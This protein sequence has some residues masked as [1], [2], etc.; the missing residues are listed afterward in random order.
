MSFTFKSSNSGLL[1]MGITSKLTLLDTNSSVNF[2]SLNILDGLV[3]EY[4]DPGILHVDMN[5]LVTAGQLITT[6]ISNLA[7]TSEK[8]EDSI[9]LSGIPTTTTA[10]TG[11]ISQI[12]TT[13]FVQNTIDNVLGGAS[14][15]LNT[16][17]KLAV[18]IDGKVS[19]ADDE[20]IGGTKTFIN[21]PV[22]SVL[23]TV[24]IV[25]N[26]SDGT[27]YTDLIKTNDINNDTIN[28]DKLQNGIVTLSK[29]APNAVDETIIATGAVTSD[30]I[31]PNAVI[32]E[33][34]NTGAVTS[35]KIAPNAV[36]TETI[37]IGAVTLLKMASDS[38]STDQ[39]VDLCVTT[40]KIN[41]RAITA[42]QIAD[43]TIT[44]D[45]FTNFAVTTDT[46]ADAA[47]TSAKLDA[48]L[49]LPFT[50]KLQL[51]P[52]E[53]GAYVNQSLVT[54]G[55]LTS[56][57]PLPS[58]SDQLPS[59]SEFFHIKNSHIT[60]YDGNPT[61]TVGAN[62]KYIVE[63][64]AKIYLPEITHEGMYFSITNKCGETIVISTRKPET[65]LTPGVYMY[66][67]FVAPDG[68]DEFEVD[69]NRTLDVISQIT[70]SESSW[71][72]RFY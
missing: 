25:H 58:S 39:L 17:Q 45:K 26:N 22:L 65:D 7:I 23:T 52:L 67:Y 60:L 24:G 21:L 27:L 38:V 57:K 68:D 71:Q 31:A 12:A 13:E 40:D 34:I 63:R 15:G 35:D 55:L 10:L 33:A 3:I 64:V 37:N 49:V 53:G 18:A 61:Y 29:M 43:Y 36:I 32:T 62:I 46:I 5:G 20:S 51:Q 50:T 4:L 48:N 28:T 59:L 6:D 47:V 1:K 56:N 14:D 72:A 9:F 54:L 19:L 11:T 70:N 16:L 2:E 30:K 66:S 8:L 44:F 41:S 69:N 42:Q